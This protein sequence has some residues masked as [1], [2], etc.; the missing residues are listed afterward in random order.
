MHS[1][2]KRGSSDSQSSVVN[3]ILGAVVD[4]D[5][6]FFADLP[7]LALLPFSLGEEDV[8]TVAFSSRFVRKSRRTYSWS[9][10]M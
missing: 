7:P 9:V 8:F 1:F 5:S 2:R 10:P 6:D 4:G 3:V